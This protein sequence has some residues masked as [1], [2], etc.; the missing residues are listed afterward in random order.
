MY[1]INESTK[2]TYLSINSVDH[3]FVQEKGTWHKL[4][5]ALYMKSSL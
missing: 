5:L 4:V 2:I 1:D 3:A